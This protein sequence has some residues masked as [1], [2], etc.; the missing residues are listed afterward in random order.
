MKRQLEK[1]ASAEAKRQEVRVIEAAAT[2]RRRAA[3]AA[4]LALAEERTKL[5]QMGLADDEIT[6]LLE[7]KERAALEHAFLDAAKRFDF[8]AVKQYVNE[9]SDLVNVQPSG[10]LSALHQAVAAMNYQI[11][12]YLLERGADPHARSADGRTPLDF[13]S[14]IDEAS[15]ALLVAAVDAKAPI[16]T[17]PDEWARQVALRKSLRARRRWR[18]IRLA[19]AVS[20]ATRRKAA[21]AEPEAVVDVADPTDR[22][23][24]GFSLLERLTSVLP[25]DGAREVQKAVESFGGLLNDYKFGD[26]TK[27]AVSSFTGK[28]GYEFGDITRAIG[29]KLLGVGDQQPSGDDPGWKR[30]GGRRC[31]VLAADYSRAR[32]AFIDLSRVLLVASDARLHTVRA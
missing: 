6:S 12:A 10:R 19:I 29:K 9:T 24:A 5:R 18:M 26:I 20:A 32:L 1:E 23:A 21:A 16:G 30:R 2:A 17:D 3:A 13:C 7:M 11:V 28:D 14:P 27:K 22:P 8:E 4:A 31:I 15:R 25:E